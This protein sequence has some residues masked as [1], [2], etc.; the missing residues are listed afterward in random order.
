MVTSLRDIPGARP[1]PGPRRRRRPRPSAGTYRPALLSDPRAALDRGPSRRR[2]LFRA[3]RRPDVFL[4]VLCLGA[5][6][7]VAY[8]ANAAWGANQVD[9]RLAGVADGSSLT[10][11]TAGEI[12]LDIRVAPATRANVTRAWVNGRE[13]T[14]ELEERDHGFGWR[15]EEQLAEGTYTIE[16]AVPRTFVGTSR[17]QRRFVVDGTAPQISAPA[18]LDPVAIDDPVV[19]EGHVDP[20]SVLLADGER[21]EHDE[22]RFALHYDI[23]PAGP[24]ALAA[25]DRSGNVAMS[26]VIVPVQHPGMRAAHVTAAAWAHDGLR[27]GV[28]DMIDEGRIDTVQLDLK[29]EG[30]EIGYDSQ[31]PLARKIGAVKAR[32]DLEEALEDLHGRG[33]SVVGRMVAFR[34]PILAKAAWEQ[35]SPDWVIQTPDGD[36][37]PSYGESFTNF[38]HP[39]VRQYNIDIAL[40]AAAAGVDDILWDYIRRPEG[41]LD[42][43]VAPGLIDPPEV[44]VADFLAE[45]FPQ[46]RAMGVYQGASVFGI[47]AARPGPVA[48]DMPRI[49]R[50]TDYVAPMVYPSLW[51]SGEYRVP[52]PVGMPREIVRA[53]LLD[54]QEKVDGTGTAI[55]PWL[56]DFSFRRVYGPA[57]VRAQICGAAE[58]GIDGWLMWSPRV[59]YSAAGMDPG[60]TPSC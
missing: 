5:I 56:Q 13:V 14:D 26:E 50:Q 35:G 27:Q 43:M 60:G 24:V 2:Q 59:R 11:V 57:E 54:F 10:L 12:E 42:D 3:K 22:G 23:P 40:E 6:G 34:D 32:Y 48:Q 15:P 17:Q 1:G 19:I 9:L 58:I 21:V 20:D 38:A 7:L 45:A 25:I 37:H 16:V 52:D 30:G 44:A 36:P 53:S 49:A 28:L 18:L 39:E 29:D 33:V 41:S 51:V 31:V 46:L 8:V 47:A 4:L 55:F